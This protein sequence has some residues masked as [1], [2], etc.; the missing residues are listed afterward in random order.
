MMAWQSLANVAQIASEMLALGQAVAAKR[1]PSVI[2][3][4]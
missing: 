2:K 1:P 4:A 3:S